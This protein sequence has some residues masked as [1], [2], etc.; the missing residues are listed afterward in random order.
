MQ[1][2]LVHG[3][4]FYGWHACTEVGRR[5]CQGATGSA[6]A[7]AQTVDCPARCAPERL[8]NF[9]CRGADSKKQTQGRLVSISIAGL[10]MYETFMAHQAA[11][12]RPGDAAIAQTAD[13]LC[14]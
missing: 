11:A 4:R 5:C 9:N 7:A 1:R 13:A 6:G 8:V 12:A 10:G 2:L 14:C 3:G